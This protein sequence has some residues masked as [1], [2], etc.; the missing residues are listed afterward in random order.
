L[1]KLEEINLGSILKRSITCK[2]LLLILAGAFFPRFFIPLLIVAFVAYVIL[3]LIRYLRPWKLSKAPGM[4]IF[5]LPLV[6]LV[7][8]AAMDWGRVRGLL[9]D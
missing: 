5:L 9:F 2:L 7:M 1:R 8:D 4:T 3:Q 6:K